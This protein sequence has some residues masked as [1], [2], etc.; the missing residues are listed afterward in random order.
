MTPRALAVP[1]ALTA[2]LLAGCSSEEAERQEA[3]CAEVPDLLSDITDDVNAIQ[4]DPQSAPQVLDEAVQQLEDV[5]PPE[6]VADEWDD[7]VTSWRALSDLLDQADLSDPA[8]NADLAPQ[9]QELQGDLVS[10][11]E[12]VDAYGEENC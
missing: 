9:L 3:F 6:A 5:D 11:G 10:S 8:A 4:S 7:L 1:F 12:A 2:L